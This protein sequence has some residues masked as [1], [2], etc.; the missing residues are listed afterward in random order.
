MSSSCLENAS[1][2]QVHGTGSWNAPGEAAAERNEE[3]GGKHDVLCCLPGRLRG[4][5]S[6]TS[7][8]VHSRLPASSPRVLPFLATRF[9]CLAVLYRRRCIFP[10]WPV[11]AAVCVFSEAQAEAR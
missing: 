6:N 2:V 1:G 10:G 9:H 11:F 5:S 8:P 4:L 3:T 7:W